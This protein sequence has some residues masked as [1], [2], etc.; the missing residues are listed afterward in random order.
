MT[1]DILKTIFEDYLCPNCKMRLT[2]A[3]S[4]SDSKL[5]CYPCN[6]SI[7]FSYSTTMII[8]KDYNTYVDLENGYTDVYANNTDANAFIS[9]N[10][11]PSKF[12]IQSIVRFIELAKTFQ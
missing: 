9:I 1:T 11:V 4:F 3:K 12:D 7:I 10:I 5:Y 6:I 8:Y 2:A